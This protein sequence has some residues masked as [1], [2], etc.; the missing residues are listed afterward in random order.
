[1]SRFDPVF[2]PEGASRVTRRLPE[3]ALVG[4][5]SN[6]SDSLVRATGNDLRDMTLI[7][8]PTLEAFAAMPRD[9]ARWLRLV[10]FDDLT[11]RHA[12][13]EELGRL[14]LVPSTT[15]VLAFFDYELASRL[16]RAADKSLVFDSY[17][18][19]NVRLDVWL[20]ILK[21]LLHGGRYIPEEL[22]VPQ[23][24]GDRRLIDGLQDPGDGALGLTPRQLG[25]LELVAA[26]L[27]NKV[28]ATRLGLSD[29]TVKLHIHNIIARLGVANRTEAAAR[30]HDMSP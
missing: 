27:P 15:V 13:G 8:L 11:M 30:F 21:L 19:L 29:H 14:P 5:R 26:G 20:S 7:H 16:Y 1:M 24:G 18:P 2:A 17:V 3:I 6:F 28:I 25:V 4:S 23:R 12:S 22:L 9:H 10:V